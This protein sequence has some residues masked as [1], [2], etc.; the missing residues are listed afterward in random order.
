MFAAIISYI[1]DVLDVFAIE[2]LH[3]R[4]RVYELSSI[5]FLA[6][7]L[8]EFTFKLSRKWKQSTGKFSRSFQKYISG[9]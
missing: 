9:K 2:L 6:F 3:T 7:V 1:R 8:H 4:V 5:C